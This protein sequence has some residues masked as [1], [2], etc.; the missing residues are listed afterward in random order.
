MKSW[1]KYAWNDYYG[2]RFKT[3]GVKGKTQ[4]T[5]PSF[6]HSFQHIT[7]AH[8]L[9]MDHVTTQIDLPTLTMRAKF[10]KPLKWTCP[11]LGRAAQVKEFR[12]I[13]QATGVK[14]GGT[15]GAHHLYKKF[16]FLNIFLVYETGWV[17]KISCTW[18]GIT[19]WVQKL[20]EEEFHNL[21]IIGIWLNGRSD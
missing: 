5:N 12:K 15:R 3:E 11:S 8:A 6:S 20:Q 18:Q 9:W 1:L 10:A 16:L 19:E 7:F 4:L 14:V 2:S 13:L 17:E 21:C